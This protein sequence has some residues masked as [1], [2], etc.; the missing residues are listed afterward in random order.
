MDHT[1]TKGTES[2]PPPHLLQALVLVRPGPRFTPPCDKLSNDVCFQL[3]RAACKPR[4]VCTCVECM[5]RSVT[6]STVT[7]THDMTT[8]PVPAPATNKRH[9]GRIGKHVPL[10]MT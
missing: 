9:G 6:D 4:S 10:L 8:G 3:E 2:F 5:L 1:S 7:Q